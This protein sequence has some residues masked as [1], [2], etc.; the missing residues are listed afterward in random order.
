MN[1][2]KHVLREISWDA[3]TDPNGVTPNEIREVL[4]ALNYK[5]HWED[6]DG[7]RTHPRAGLSV[8]PPQLD[9][10]NGRQPSCL[11]I[12]YR[13]RDGSGHCVVQERSHSY[14]Y[15][16]YQIKPEGENVCNDIREGVVKSRFWI[17][18][19]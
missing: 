9:I 3:P 18:E 6:F 16:D 10:A 15:S 4:D 1:R 11:A 19:Q 7:T 12:L 17:I 8:H 2:A 13:M 14:D 5:Y